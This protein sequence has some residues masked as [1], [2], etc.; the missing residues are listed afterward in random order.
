MGCGGTRGLLGCILIHCWYAAR[1]ASTRIARQHDT[2][3]I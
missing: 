1:R 2:T 3:Q